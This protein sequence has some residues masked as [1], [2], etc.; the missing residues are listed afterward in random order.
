MDAIP[1]NKAQK[2]LGFRVRVRVRVRVKIIYF[3]LCRNSVHRNS[4]PEPWKVA[5]KLAL[6]VPSFLALM[7]IWTHSA[8]TRNTCHCPNHIQRAFVTR[9]L[10]DNQ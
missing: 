9:N 2:G 3:S 8:A 1:T 6:S 7:G 5:A 10:L 4:D